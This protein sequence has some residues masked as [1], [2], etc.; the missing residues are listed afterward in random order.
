V[1]LDRSGPKA[2]RLA[3]AALILL[4]VAGVGASLL[5]RRSD[6]EPAASDPAPDAATVTSPAAGNTPAPSTPA[7]QAPVEV[8]ETE[9]EPNAASPAP[10]RTPGPRTSTPRETP[11]P[12]VQEPE[13]SVP[14]PA[15]T[16]PA[17]SSA[18]YQP[19]PQPDET[20]PAGGTG[21]VPLDELRRLGGELAGGTERLFTAFQTYLEQKN[22]A[23]QEIT[24]DDEQL[25]EDLE[26]LQS[27]AERFNGS[28]QNGMMSRLR[29]MGR[30]GTDIEQ[31]RRKLAK[32]NERGERVESLIGR[33]QPGPEVQQ[34]WQGVRRRWR[35]V[36]QILS[37]R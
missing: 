31:L 3:L 9:P 21:E 25:E 26:A 14:Q 10:S 16:E 34:E 30:S 6:P 5:F 13:P 29:R 18:P 19:A 11:R 37:E 24:G 12:I 17:Q 20:A 15:H 22:D 4:I 7:T 33:V 27:A 28:F 8:P 23:D 1:R 36:G 32:L 35:R 2:G